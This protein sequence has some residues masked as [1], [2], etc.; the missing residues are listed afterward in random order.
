MRRMYSQKQLEAIAKAVADT[1]IG[2]AKIDVSQLLQNPIGVVGLPLVVEGHGT[3]A[4]K[5]IAP[6]AIK[7]QITDAGRALVVGNDGTVEPQTISGG[8]QLYRH[9]ITLVMTNNGVD[10]NYYFECFS[11]YGEQ[12]LASHLYYL[13]GSKLG[14]IQIVTD[15]Y[16]VLTI[17]QNDT[18]FKFRDELGNFQKDSFHTAVMVYP[19]ANPT[20]NAYNA[21][22]IDLSTGSMNARTASSTASFKSFS[23]DVTEL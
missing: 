17:P 21:D 9:H 14:W 1:E 3:I 7:G 10:S 22:S 6:S 2:E 8:T 19:G 23:D 15:Y 4:P 12:F 16:M 18:L 11:T 13:F 5:E 20:Y